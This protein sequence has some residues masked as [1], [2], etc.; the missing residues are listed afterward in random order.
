MKRPDEH[1]VN[2]V[3]ASERTTPSVAPVIARMA[4]VLWQADA[5][6]RVNSVTLCQPTLSAREGA[7][8]DNEVAQIEQLW[9]KC[10]LC[11][12]RFNTVFHVRS[13]SGPYVRTFA[14]RA[15][16]VLD[17]RD[18]VR[19]WAGS[20][21]EV[22]GF[23]DAATRFL[24]DAST[25]LSSSLNHTTIVNRLVQTSV[26]R[27]CDLC[28]IHRLDDDGA[29]YLE[30]V[31]GRRGEA[32]AQPDGLDEVL[33]DVLRTRQPVLHLSGRVPD[34]RSLIVAPV[35]VGGSCIATLSFLESQM[36]SS[37]VARDVDVAVVVARQ[38]AMALENIK[39]FEREQHITERFRYLARVTERLFTTLDSTKMLQTLLESITDGFADY[40]VAAALS[41]NRLQIVTQ[42]NVKTPVFRDDAEREMIACLRQRRSILIGAEPDVRRPLTVGPLSEMVRPLSWMMVPLFSHDTVYGALVCCSNA[43]PYDPSDLELLEEIGRRASLALDHAES[44]ARERRITHTL[45]QATLPTQLAEVEGASLSAVYRPADSDLRVGGDWYDAFDLDDRRVLLT[46][47]DVTG[48]GL[49]A[50]IVMGKLRHAINVIAMYERNPVRILN[51]AERIL[52][53]RYPGS[54]A[55]AFVAVID[56]ARGTITYANAGHPYPIARRADGTLQELRAEGLPVGLRSVGGE[57]SPVTEQLADTRMLAFYTDGLTDATRDTLA[58]EKLLHEALSSDVIFFVGSPA[59]FI[60]SFCV[61]TQS[62]DDVAVLTLNFV[63]CRRWAFDSRD[64]EAARAA[65]R[66]FAAYTEAT[67]GP[68]SD[69]KA[70]ELIFGE[71]AADAAQHAA[72]LVEIALDWRARQAVLHVI[73]HSSRYT[74]P[75]GHATDLLAEQ[76]RGFWLVQRLGARLEVEILP[77]FGAHIAATLPV[78]SE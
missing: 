4:E 70:A 31:A 74:A 24:S 57:S 30:G 44:F 9:R 26:D 1:E 55:T 53:R 59:R 16:P 56:S 43:H 12:E 54:V 46:V 27:F 62:P 33:A 8:D 34:T 61:R 51:A 68:K 67:A 20:A 5:N 41:D 77:G 28:F 45:Q 15:V 37:F 36:P 76:E 52:L 10:V 14:L 48:H 71:L 13:R 40:A 39:T 47:G 42:C 2:R 65:R 22:D 60:E 64:W 69:L 63:Q 25:V 29:L 66:E 73:D 6:G 50:S 17:D 75:N 58:G 72:G 21:I 11:A 3:L 38:L 18:D 19:Y 32:A 49:Q 78:T 35:V 7:L 23:A